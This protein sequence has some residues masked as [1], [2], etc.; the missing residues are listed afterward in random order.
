DEQAAASAKELDGLTHEYG[1]LQSTIREKSP[2]Y[3]AL[4][5]PVPLSLAEIQKS[6]LDS[7][8]V[9]LE[10][11]L[12]EEKSFLFAVTSQAIEAVELPKRQTIE[13]AA[14]RVY[15]VLIARNQTTA[16]E[17]PQQRMSRIRRAEADYPAAAAELSR[18][19]L[20]PVAERLGSKR[21]LIVAE[22]ALQYIPFI[23]LPDPQAKIAGSAQPLLAGHE[24]VTA[25]SASVLALIRNDASHRRPAEK[26]LAVFADPVFD[27]EDSRIMRSQTTPGTPQAQGNGP[28][29][30]MRSGAEAGLQHFERLRFSR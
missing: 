1:Q 20:G 8:T 25:P 16:G 26:Q 14:R 11:S 27:R 28:A 6:V 17:T 22:G 15:D 23:A 13:T 10:Y 4:T 7:D 5:M 2:A 30:V 9:L 24:I 3:A 18:M 29:E 19:L 21:L 12:G